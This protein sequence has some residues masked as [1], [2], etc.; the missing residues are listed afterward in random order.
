MRDAAAEAAVSVGVALH[1]LVVPGGMS[2][3]FADTATCVADEA[4]PL[5][6]F[7]HGWPESWFSW[8]HQLKAVKAAGYRGV[9]PDMRGYGSSLPFPLDESAQYL[10]STR[11]DDVLSLMDHLGA[12]RAALVAHDH[13]AHTAW[14]IVRIAP[15]RFSC[16]TALSVPIT[17]A[18]SKPPLMYLRSLFGDE[19][20]PEEDPAFMYQLH[21]C[22]PSAAASYGQNTRAALRSLFADRASMRGAAPPL[23]DSPSLYVDG[24]A[25]PLWKR[26]KQPAGPPSWMSADEF[27]YFVHE[28]ER[29]GWAGGL[30]WYAV[31]VRPSS[32][33]RRAFRT[34]GRNPMSPTLPPRPPPPPPPR[35]LRIWITSF[36]CFSFLLFLISFVCSLLIS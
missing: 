14:S 30:Q 5:V 33:S 4:K 35:V 25:E 18:A 11:T 28:Y 23:V 15:E 2:M 17:A 6:V 3:R 12:E 9:A 34:L 36:V 32:P 8:R 29:S 13:G 1:S 24:V 7:L 10:L 19:S 22:L 20:K 21:H 26:T 27:A 31:Q 16:Y